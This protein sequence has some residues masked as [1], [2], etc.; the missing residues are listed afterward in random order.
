MSS[1]RAQVTGWEEVEVSNVKAALQLELRLLRIKILAGKL[2]RSQVAFLFLGNVKA[3][4]YLRPSFGAVMM[5]D[6][7]DQLLSCMARKHNG[8]HSPWWP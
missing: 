6:R 3:G 8:G 7:S 1:I 4:D 5:K 2:V